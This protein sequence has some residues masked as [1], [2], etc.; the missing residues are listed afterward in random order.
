MSILLLQFQCF[1]V[2]I[3]FRLITMGLGN[4]R[5]EVIGYDHFGTPPINSRLRRTLSIKEA[6]CWLTLAST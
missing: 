2:F 3:K 6:F 4:R 5:L 1:K